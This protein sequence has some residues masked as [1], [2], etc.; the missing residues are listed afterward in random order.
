MNWVGAQ[1]NPKLCI[2]ANEVRHTLKNGNR[3]THT[4]CCHLFVCVP[5]K[6]WGFQSKELS[7][8]GCKLELLV[9]Q[10]QQKTMRKK[11]Q[12]FSHCGSFDHPDLQSLNNYNLKK[13]QACNILLEKSWNLKFQTFQLVD[14][15]NKYSV[16]CRTQWSKEPQWEN[17]CS[18]FP[19][20]FVLV[21]AHAKFFSSQSL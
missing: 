4:W 5:S 20:I 3:Q 10:H 13:I 1:D 11:P 17:E 7:D 9:S 12:S 15:K 8:N 2:I 6:A 14:Q 18:S 16:D 19:H 21:Q